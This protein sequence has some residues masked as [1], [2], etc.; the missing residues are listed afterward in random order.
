MDLRFLAGVW[1]A[2]TALTSARPACAVAI[3]VAAQFAA[4]PKFIVGATQTSGFCVDIMQAVEKR[5]PALQFVVLPGALPL[6]RI[7]SDMEAGKLDANCLIANAERRSKFHVAPTKLF[8]YN[9]HLIVRAQDEV[10]VKQW[11][12]VR[13]LGSEGRILVVKGTGAISRLEQAGGLILD[14][15]GATPEIN[16]QKLLAGRG[17]FFYYRTE[18]WKHAMARSGM[19]DKIKVLPGVMGVEDFYLMLGKHLPP[20]LVAAVGKTLAELD[21]TGELERIHKKW[22]AN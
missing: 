17:R 12:D 10:T 3:R 22:A 20:S 16:L 2:A 18:G 7:Q 6:T 4:E 5:N 1:L 21:D 15:G 19:E 9:Y 8:S 14:A 13:N 11:D